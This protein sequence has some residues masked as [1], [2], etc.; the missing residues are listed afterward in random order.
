MIKLRVNGQLH[1]LDGVDPDTPLLWILRDTLGLK[2]T[3]YG[4]GKNQCGVCNV[5][6][7]GRLTRACTQQI[8]SLSGSE[9]TT[10]EGLS[11]N[12]DHRVQQ[13]WKEHAVPQCGFCQVGQIMAAAALLDEIPSPTDKDI[14]TIMSGNLCRCG[15]YQRIRAA[16]HTAAGK[17]QK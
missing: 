14:D 3:K 17:G 1:E 7:D 12:G 2:G 5:H 9:V 6:V 11:P 16:I 13:A 15:T 10:I 8:G 4:C